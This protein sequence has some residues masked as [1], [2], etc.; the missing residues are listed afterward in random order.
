MTQAPTLDNIPLRICI[1]CTASKI[2]YGMQRNRNWVTEEIRMNWKTRLKVKTPEKV[3][4]ASVN[5][6]WDPVTADS[7]QISVRQYTGIDPR[8][9]LSKKPRTGW[10]QEILA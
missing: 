8:I 1:L 2:L 3:I 5:Q 7:Q 9:Y 10:I 6:V 4:L